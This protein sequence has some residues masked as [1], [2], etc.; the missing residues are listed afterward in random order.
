L[1]DASRVATD[2][3]PILIFCWLFLHEG[4]RLPLIENSNFFGEM[5]MA[6]PAVTRDAFRDV[7]AFYAAKALHDHKHDG[8]HS[9]LKLFGS[10]EDIPDRLLEQWSGGAEPLGSENVG[11][12][13]EPRARQIANGGTRYDHASGFL[14]ALLRDLGQKVQ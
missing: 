1:P 4:F 12:I 9:L 7:F 10:A 6:K 13:L 8:E 11:R 14:L 2:R 5:A 3:T